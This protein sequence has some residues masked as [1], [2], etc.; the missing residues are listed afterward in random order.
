[1]LISIECKELRECRVDD[2][3]LTLLHLSAEYMRAKLTKYLVDKIQIG[4]LNAYK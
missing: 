1:M 3:E 4:K 2:D